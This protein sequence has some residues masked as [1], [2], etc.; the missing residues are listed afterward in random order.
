MNQINAAIYGGG[1]F[2]SGGQAVVDDLKGSGFTTVIAWSVHVS[3]N[4]DLVYNDPTIVSKGQYVGDSGW[5]GLLANLKQGGSVNRLLFSVGSGGVEDFHHIQNLINTEG[6]GPGSILYQNFKA[7]KDAIP[8]IDAIDLDDEDLND[9]A[10]TVAFSRMLHTIGYEVT[11]CPYTN[12]DFWVGCLHTL[13]SKTPNL[14]TAFNL[15]CYAG[16][17]GNHPQDWIDAIAARM[18]SGFDAKGFVYP[19]LWSADGGSC[20]NINCPDDIASQFANWK[21]TGVQGGFMWL[22]DDIQ[23]CE[24]T[25]TCSPPANTAGYA[26]AIINGLS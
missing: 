22:Y 15:Q 5:P 9:S 14:V 24:G 23:K 18:G 3:T 13:N 12:T 11:F 6:T 17:E 10:T 20:D 1:P 7:L 4:G 19:G 8:D 2:Y 25:Q 21:S 26:H 16:G